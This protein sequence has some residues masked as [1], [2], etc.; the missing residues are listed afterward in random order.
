MFSL[1]LQVSPELQRRAVSCPGFLP[2]AVLSYIRLHQV[3]LDGLEL[4]AAGHLSNHQVT[5]HP[6]G[7][8][9][10]TRGFFC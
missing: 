7:G 6:D 1:L 4:G 2:T 5:E 10:H 8:S 9:C 3:Y